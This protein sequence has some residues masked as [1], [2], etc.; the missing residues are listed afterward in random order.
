MRDSADPLEL[1][2]STAGHGV[3]VGILT[4]RHDRLTDLCAP[5]MSYLF[6]E[7]AERTDLLRSRS[8]VFFQFASFL[9][10]NSMSLRLKRKFLLT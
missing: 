3:T 4:T 9:T 6:V 8:D 7:S 10:L 5:S 1:R 2:D